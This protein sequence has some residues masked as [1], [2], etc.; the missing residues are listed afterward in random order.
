L[1]E[2]KIKNYLIES[3][4]LSYGNV[5]VLFFIG[6]TCGTIMFTAVIS[7]TISCSLGWQLGPVLSLS[8]L[9][10]YGQQL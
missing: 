9:D 5:F 2:N 7:I 10:V 3:R 8:F 4:W 6:T 1:A